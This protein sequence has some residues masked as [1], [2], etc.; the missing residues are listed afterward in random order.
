MK[1]PLAYVHPN[2]KIA[3]NVA[4]DPFVFIDNDV[5]I[6]EG[7]WIGTG[8][9]IYSGA[10][11]GKNCKIFP[12]AVISAI[13]QDL[14]FQGEYTTVEIGNNVTIRE[15]VTINR[16]TVD[17]YKTVVKDNT[18]LMAYV[19]VAHDCIVGRN[20]I[21]A[22]AVNMAGHVVID[23]FAI[24]GGMSAIHQFVTIGKHVMIAGGS[25]IGKDIPP[26]TKAGRYPISYEGINSIGLR[27]RGFDNKT[28]RQIQ[29]IYRVIYL[30]GIRT[31]DALTIIER[32]FEATEERDEI[33][34]F[35]RN[36]GAHGRGIM[37]GYTFISDRNKQ[38]VS[39]SDEQ[40]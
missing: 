23:D 6:D 34:N 35:I 19:H 37:K 11:I 4:I 5:V 18:L 12:G 29:E 15:C 13:P 38:S 8:A 24:V 30:S 1:Q 39:N 10:R 27:R 2:A 31:S 22:N 9:V 32:D 3:N 7:T 16:G 14:K 36:S 25:L 26:Y 28:I 33:L 20:C 17:R 21:L 40:N